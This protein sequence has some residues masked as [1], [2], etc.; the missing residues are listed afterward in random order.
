M[1]AVQ[2]AQNGGP[3]VLHV[4]EVDEPHAGAGQVRVAVKAV[5]INP[6]DFK[7]RSG[8]FGASEHLPATTALDA[9][10]VVDEVGEGVSDVAGRR[11]GLRPGRRRCGRRVRRARALGRQARQPVVRG[12]RRP[13]RGR[14]DG[15]AGVPPGRPRRPARPCSST[16]PPGAWA[17]PPCSWPEPRGA[18][19]VIGTA[20]ESNHDF[21]RSLGVVPTTYGE[22]L[23]DRVRA[24]APDGID[25]A[26]DTAGRGVLP[27]LVELTGD[28]QKVVTIASYDAADYG[29]Q[30]TTG[31][32]EA[33][34]WDALGRAAELFRAGPVQPAGG[35]G[36]PVRAGRRRAPAQ[37][38]RP[39]ARQ[40]GA[41][42]P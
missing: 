24:L 5:G 2:F 34:S 17:P 19:T 20:S 40:A 6:V 26:F 37:R 28:P 7:I 35:A 39:R 1:R 36:L 31:G 3:E 22:G 38:G 27:A 4:A 8:Q 32:G 16:A 25:L 41:R 10:G 9:S 13:A 14:R 30:L 29:V 18:G 12:G 15:A 11:R 23:V 42:P 21:L 33:R